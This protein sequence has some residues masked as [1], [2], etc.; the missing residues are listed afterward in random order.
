M[1]WCPKQ[2]AVSLGRL[3]LK[4]A[5]RQIDQRSSRHML[6]IIN[7]NSLHVLKQNFM[8]LRIPLTL[9]NQTQKNWN[10]TLV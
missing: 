3:Y 4:I 1:Y 2:S 7:V 8:G 6:S 9:F 5:V 10:T